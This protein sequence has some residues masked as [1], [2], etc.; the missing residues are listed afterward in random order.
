MNKTLKHISLI[1][2]ALI[3]INV[4]SSK[5]YKR[6]DLTTDKRY[7]L[8]NSALE[9]IKKA[10]KPVV[11]DV[12]L[13]GEDFPSEFRRLKNETKQLLEEFSAFND[14]ISFKFINPIEDENT[15]DQNIKQLNARGLTP[16]QLNVKENGKSSQAVILHL[17]A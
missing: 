6:F 9:I 3:A 1:V 16:M 11:I 10:D 7:T 8:N 14:N 5:I 13:E 4:I 12:F 2:I 15:R 17:I